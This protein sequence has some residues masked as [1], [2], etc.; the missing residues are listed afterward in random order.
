MAKIDRQ[1]GEGEQI[2]LNLHPHW[3]RLVLPFLFVPV[4]VGGAAFAISAGPDHPIYYWLIVGVAFVLLILF[5]LLPFWRWQ[6]TTTSSRIG[7]CSTGQGSL[8]R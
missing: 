7:A 3:R 1:L 6:T 5:S 2:V 4:V 8:R